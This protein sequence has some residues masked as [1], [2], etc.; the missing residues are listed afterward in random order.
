MTLKSRGT[1][2]EAFTVLLLFTVDG[3]KKYEKFC[4]NK[5]V[6]DA[7]GTEIQFLNDKKQVSVTPVFHGG[8]NVF[9]EIM[10]KNNE[11][12]YMSRALR[13]G[14]TE[15]LS[16][17]NSFEGYTFNFHEKTKILRLRKDTLLY[18]AVKT[19]Y[20][21]EDFIGRVF[22]IDKA[23]FDQY[24]HGELVE[25]V[26]HFNKAFVRITEKKDDGIFSGEI[27]VKTY[28]TNY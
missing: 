17:L 6:I 26:Y 10:D 3:K 19:F 25:R 13:S 5:C 28:K 1:D 27:F 12:V 8:N 23:Y 24:I 2:Y 14:Q 21:Q 16:D 20:A 11:K 9:F 4:Y 18:T 7:E 22:K 15:V